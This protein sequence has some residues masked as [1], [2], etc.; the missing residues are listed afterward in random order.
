MPRKKR[1]ALPAPGPSLEDLAVERTRR[2]QERAKLDT[3]LAEL[4]MHA[5]IRRE[6]ETR[7][8]GLAIEV[9]S[10]GRQYT[11]LASR[12]GDLGCYLRVAAVPIPS[13]DPGR[14][15]L[16]IEGLLIALDE[17]IWPP[18]VKTTSTQVSRNP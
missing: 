15:Q 7:I 2:H 10:W 8:R 3:Q 18:L 13:V 17:R 5:E 14:G 16:V 11:D 12:A 1:L 4:T 9:E 6:R